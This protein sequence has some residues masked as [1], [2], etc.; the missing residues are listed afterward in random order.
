MV[1]ANNNTGILTTHSPMSNDMTKPQR[2]SRLTT[3]LERKDLRSPERA[4][5]NQMKTRRAWS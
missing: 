1:M 2:S 4:A 5:T 3:A